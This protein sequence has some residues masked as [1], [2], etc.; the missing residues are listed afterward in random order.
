[1]ALVPVGCY[2]MGSSGE[3]IDY[4]LNEMLDKPT[5]YIFEGPA[6]QQCFDTPFWIDVYE[7]TSGQ[8]GSYDVRPGDELPR[9]YISWFDSAAHCETRGAR[10]PTE[11]EWEYA[12]RGPDSLIYPWGN[13]FDPSRLNYCEANCRDH[14][15]VD[16][17]FDDGHEL[18]AP[19]GSF[20]SG[21]SWVGAL[22]MSGNLWEWTSGI[23]CAYPY[24][25]DQCEV[26]QEN[27]SVRY[28]TL[29]GGSWNGANFVVRTANRNE[30]A[31]IDQAT[32]FG[33]RCVRSV[34]P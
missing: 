19:V 2:M 22:D 7:V 29:R 23:L 17:S 33:F 30:H 28:R 34:E 25:V 11:A 10:L 31:P 4:A 21:V 18:S 6:H 8:Y 9:D 27:D 20:P 1:M 3:Q 16:L 26:S 12:A 5:F 24:S 15:G 32:I 14:P 13:E